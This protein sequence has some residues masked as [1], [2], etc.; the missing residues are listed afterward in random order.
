MLRNL[1]ISIINAKSILLLFLT[2]CENKKSINFE[3]FCTKN[4][5]CTFLVFWNWTRNRKCQIVL[6]FFYQ[7]SFWA[8]YNLFELFFYRIF[9]LCKIRCDQEWLNLLVTMKFC[10]F[11]IYHQRFI[12]VISTNLTGITK[13]VLNVVS[14]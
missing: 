6:T 14:S 7:Q 1:W 9:T 12:F 11:E 4:I 2:F 10:K 5:L 8:F 3:R 13:N